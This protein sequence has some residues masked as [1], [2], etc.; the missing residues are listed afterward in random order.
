MNIYEL[1][2]EILR[3]KKEKD[4]CILAHSYQAKEIAE[5]ADF[6]GDSYQLSVMAAKAPQKTVIM[7]GVRFMAETVKIL[8]P[9]KTVYLANPIAGCPMAEQMDKDMISMVKEQ[10]PDYTVVAYINTTAELKTICDVCV[11]SSSAVKIV[12]KL[13]NKNILF[14]PDCNLGNYVSQQVPEKNFKLLQG[15]CPIHARVS[16]KDVEKA[17]AAHPDAKVL[18]HPECTPDVLK[19]ADFIGSTSA[20]VEEAAKADG[21]EFIIGTEISIAQQLAFRCPE[22]RF[23]PLSKNLI[24]PNMKSTTLVDVFH[25][26]N[27]EGGEEIIMDMETIEQARKCIDKMIELG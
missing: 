27:G 12:K 23:Y 9:D 26:V 13:E 21:K 16:A 22:K 25:T 6:T 19:L 4:I 11:T 5:I 24:C 15:G 2:Q 14:I 17:K 20:I 3:I 8:S 1:Q 7:C 10:Y 18:V